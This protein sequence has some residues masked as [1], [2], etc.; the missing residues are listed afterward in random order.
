MKKNVLQFI[1]SFHQGGSER[2]A[3][4]L[5]KLLHEDENF[6]VFATTLNRE[7]ILL[8]ELEKLGLDDIPEFKLTS[9]FNFQFL[10]QIRNCAEFLK[11]NEIE[12][13]HTHDFYTNVF[14][15]LAA[16]LAGVP[17][18]IASKRETGGMRSANQKRLEKFIFRLADKITVNAAAVRDYLI[19]NKVD[20]RK[21]EIIYNGLDLERLKPKAIDREQ[22]CG[23][24]KLPKSEDIKFITQVA[25]LRHAVKN[26]E[27]TLRAAAEIGKV[28]PDAHFVFAGEGERKPGLEALAGKLNV[29][30]KTHFIGRCNLIPE[31][32]SVSNICLLTSTAEGFSNSILEY[33]AAAKPVIA[34]DVGGAAEAIVEKKTGYLIKSDD[35]KALAK[36]LLKLLDSPEKASEMGKRGRK[37]VEEN[38]S[39][40]NQLRKTIRL[41]KSLIPSG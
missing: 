8:A 26:Q 18:K 25:N 23:K 41:Y 32:L 9:F 24:L 10:K 4:Q 20:E 17:V 35:N 34:T 2:Q 40:E 12:I 31:L 22:I 39:T 1:G 13:V 11:K 15:I 27:M 30:A 36:Y 14:G 21:I 16:N 7:G 3:V 38:F 6:K 33:M 19:E 5:V 28:F 37:I 29:E